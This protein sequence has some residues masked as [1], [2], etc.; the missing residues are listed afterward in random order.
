MDRA[1]TRKGIENILV[2]PLRYLQLTLDKTREYFMFWPSNNSSQISNLNRMLSFGLYLP[3][4][5]LGLGFSVSRWR[6]FTP[7][8]IFIIIHT[9]V[10]LLTWPAPRY[11]LPVDAV[12]MVFAGL[13]ISRLALQIKT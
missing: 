5:L 7:L 11:R 12:L 4:M 13:A 2:D 6:S 10:H 1:L 8:Y 9:S 3:F